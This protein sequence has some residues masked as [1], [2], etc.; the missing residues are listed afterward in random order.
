MR[1]SPTARRL[2]AAVA[3]A[4]ATVACRQDMHDQPKYVPLRGS[5][6]FADGA[7]A[8]PLP[9][10][11]V[12]RGQLHEDAVLYTGKVGEEPTAEMPF[13]VTE[14][15]MARGQVAFNAYCS[16][17]HGQTG[18]GD[19]MVVQ[20]GYTRPPALWSERVRTQPVGHIFDVITNGFGA[21]PDHA[22]Q[23]KVSDR[24]AIAAYVR[25]L[26][27]AAAG[28]VNDVPAA[29]REQLDRPAGAA[30]EAAEAHGGQ[31]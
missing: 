29:Q 27:V 22:A 14:Q 28:T 3:L 10:G 31:H 1:T 16:H 24:W 5:T 25:A 7:S 18:D 13:P 21:M 19:G 2:L 9:A 8:R 11:T 23:V 20:R 30:A 12:A 26:Q 6:F 17:C 4:C 15:V